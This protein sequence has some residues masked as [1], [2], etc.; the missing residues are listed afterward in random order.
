MFLRLKNEEKNQ[1]SRGGVFGPYKEIGV[2]FGL[3]FM[4]FILKNFFL[5]SNKVE[6]I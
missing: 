3:K 6:H 2:L 5:K 1:E 4:K